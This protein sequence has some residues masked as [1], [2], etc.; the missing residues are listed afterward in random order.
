MKRMGWIVVLAGVLLFGLPALAQPA[1]APAGGGGAVKSK[2]YDFSD[3][4]IDGDIKKPTTL[5]TDA[6][7]RVKFDRLLRLKK[8]FLQ[9]M[10]QS[11]KE[12]VF[13]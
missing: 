11:A 4:L 6:R 8:S 1:K 13:K 3:Q 2:F 9:P 5:Y 12:Q 10:L 7:Q